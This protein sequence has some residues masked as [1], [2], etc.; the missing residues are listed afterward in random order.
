MRCVTQM[1]MSVLRITE[2]AVH[3]LTAP[4]HMEAII[5]PVSRDMSVTE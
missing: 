2:V 5:A 3:M 1:W 4:T